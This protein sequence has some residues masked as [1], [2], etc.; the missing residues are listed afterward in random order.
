VI[1]PLFDLRQDVQRLSYG[2]NLATF[3][4]FV[5]QDA[6]LNCQNEDRFELSGL[7]VAGRA[8]LGFSA[9]KAEGMRIVSDLIAGWYPVSSRP[10]IAWSFVSRRAFFNGSMT[11]PP[12]IFIF[13]DSIIATE[14]RYKLINAIRLSATPALRNARIEP[15]LTRATSVR[16]E[17]MRAICRVLSSTVVRC[18]VHARGNSPQLNVM[19]GGMERVYGFVE[20]CQV[21]GHLLTADSLQ[22]A[23]R[24]AGRAFHNQ[25]SATF[26]VLVDGAQPVAKFFV[27]ASRRQPQQPV[28]VD[29]PTTAGT[30]TAVRPVVAEPTPVVQNLFFIYSLFFIMGRST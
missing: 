7:A 3:V 12:I 24:S 25:L 19:T 2:A 4:L 6:A 18:T 28:P 22:F 20:S 23:Y 14:I 30:S 5:Q 13:K 15:V 27:P 16:V 9:Q 8:P 29:V 11:L 10:S 21:F 26:L 17:V 1:D